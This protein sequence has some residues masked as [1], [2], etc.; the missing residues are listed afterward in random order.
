MADHR[1]THI[2]RTPGDASLTAENE[3]NEDTPLLLA[4]SR[5]VSDGDTDEDDKSLPMAQI[6]FL[7]AA[8]LIELIAFFS[9]FSYINKMC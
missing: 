1:T 7:C 4:T 3:I 6:L 2:S 9:I 5:D 8:R